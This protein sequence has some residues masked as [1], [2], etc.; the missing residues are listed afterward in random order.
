MNGCDRRSGGYQSQKP[1]R[2]LN[3]PPLIAPDPIDG[4][5]PQ[6]RWNRELL[7]DAREEKFR[8]MVAEIKTIA[9]TVVSCEPSCLVTC[10]RAEGDVKE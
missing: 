8:A 10:L 2:F 6:K 1:A 9:S 5:A 4:V 7:E 3:A